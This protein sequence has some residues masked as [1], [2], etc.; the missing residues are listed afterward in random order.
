MQTI[1]ANS[2]AANNW[3]MG[4]MDLGSA[5]TQIAFIPQNPG[6]VTSPNKAFVQ[7][8]DKEYEIYTASYQ[9][10]GIQQAYNRYV[11]ALIKV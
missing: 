4:A 10:Y 11:A 2:I 9:C 7:V 5:S 3:T 6:Q 1:P 8:F